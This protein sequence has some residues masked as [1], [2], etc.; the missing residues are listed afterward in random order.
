MFVLFGIVMRLARIVGCLG[1]VGVRRVAAGS[2][3]LAAPVAVA[4]VIFPEPV[5]K[6]T[7]VKSY[8]TAWSRCD[9]ELK[10]QV[11]KEMVNFVFDLR[12]EVEQKQS[13]DPTQNLRVLDLLDKNSEIFTRELTK[14]CIAMNGNVYKTEDFNCEDEI[15]RALGIALLSL[16]TVTITDLG[17]LTVTAKVTNVDKFLSYRNLMH[18]AFEDSI[19]K[20]IA[21]A[22]IEFTD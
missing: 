5:K 1:R 3:L 15:K 2:I 17:G 18:P 20:S 11:C 4:P 12:N 16:G 19:S 13:T 9:K 6:D 22:K 21:S 8:L 14:K 10:P 7:Q